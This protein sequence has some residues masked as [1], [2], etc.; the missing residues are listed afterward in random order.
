MLSK[1]VQKKKMSTRLFSSV[2]IVLMVLGL[3][4][5]SPTV[6]SAAGNREKLRFDYSQEH[7]CN[8]DKAG[9]YVQN[10]AVWSPSMKRIIRVQIKPSLNGG[11]AG[12]Y[13]LDGLRAVEGRNAW[14]FDVKAQRV[15]DRDDINLIMPTGG[16]SSFYSDW[17]EPSNLNDQKFTYKWET[18]LTHELPAYLWRYFGVSQHNNAIGG[19]SM[20]GSA[21]LI[22]AAYHHNQ[23]RQALSFS[24][25]LHPAGLGMKTGIRLAMLDSG[26]YNVDSMWGLP[27]DPAWEE[28]DPF[29][30]SER[31]R[32]LNLYL[33]SGFG[34]PGAHD[35]LADILQP[36]TTVSSM[37]LESLAGL[38]HI[39]M[40]LKL[41]A[42]GIPHTNSY[43]VLGTHAWGYWEDELTKA[44][45]SILRTLGVQ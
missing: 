23:F 34:I 7:H 11:H 26:S 33:S 13:L 32:G 41:L 18:F 4:T 44:R 27:G 25:Y 5:L 14:T 40:D 39:A 42:E 43:T 3:G 28:H 12:L 37:S 24:G 21:A 22:L 6:S 45:P 15:F 35:S 19:V 30:Q 8:W 17:Y 31:L 29:I 9:G 1:L 20:G 2:L 38:S 36:V 16:Q 10:C